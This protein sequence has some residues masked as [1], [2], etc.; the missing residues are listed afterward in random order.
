MCVLVV[1][2][3]L[4]CRSQ[5]LLFRHLAAPLAHGT[6]GEVI[7]TITF[8]ICLLTT[9]KVELV[10][11]LLLPLA[12]PTPEEWEDEEVE[13]LPVDLQYLGEDKERE[14]DTD[15]RVML[16]ER[17]GTLLFPLLESK[18]NL[19]SLT[20]LCAT[21]QGRQ[22]MREQNVYLVLRQYHKVSQKRLQLTNADPLR[23]G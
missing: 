2:L 7:L 4:L 5:E 12:G 3:G 9:Y 10:S 23:E 21:R 17:Q 6:R 16:L 11:R 22:R 15:L 20:Q 13:R 14:Q 19:C 8:N 1:E 18:A